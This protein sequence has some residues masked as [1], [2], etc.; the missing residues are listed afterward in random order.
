MFKRMVSR[1]GPN[2]AARKGLRLIPLSLILLLLQCGL[3][4][5]ADGMFSPKCLIKL[6]EDKNPLTVFS[7]P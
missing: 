4:Q 7:V 3:C 5:D 2:S 6:R 1:P